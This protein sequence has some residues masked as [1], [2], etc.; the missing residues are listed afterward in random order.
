MKNMIVWL[1]LLGLSPLAAAAPRVAL[2]REYRTG[3][4]P[5]SW[6]RSDRCEV[7]LKETRITRTFQGVS[8]TEIR[9]IVISDVNDLLLKASQG[10]ITSENGPV[11]SPTQVYYG[12][13]EGEK[14]SLQ[15]V[16]LYEEN[17]EVGLLKY[18]NAEAAATLRHLLDVNCA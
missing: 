9:T 17:G 3:F 15:K 13:L 4:V 10:K 5:A 6:T 2:V 16:D 12:Y 18:N 1:S 11:D 8:S 14:G 7:S